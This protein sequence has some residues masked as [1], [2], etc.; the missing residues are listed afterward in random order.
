MVVR[1]TSQLCK[2]MW[3]KTLAV[4]LPGA[5]AA[6]QTPLADMD[7]ERHCALCMSYIVP[8]TFTKRP[9][10]Q[11]CSQKPLYVKSEELS[12]S[13]HYEEMAN[14]YHPE[15]VIVEKGKSVTM[16]RKEIGEL[17]KKF[18]EEI[19]S[20]KFVRKNSVYQ[21]TEDYLI[22]Q[23]DF[24]V[25]SDKGDHKGNFIHIWKKTDGSWLIFHEEFEMN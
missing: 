14:F 21:G 7:K 8:Y 22:V 17:F 9:D 1:L 11:R 24:E 12:G 4:F 15:G 2:A 5:D 20:H 3:W 13:G 16:G 18:F 10:Y 25:Q 23:S 6:T 19:G